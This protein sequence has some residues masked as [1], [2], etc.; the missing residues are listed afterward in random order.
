MQPLSQAI[1][2]QSSIHGGSPAGENIPAFD[3]IQSRSGAEYTAPDIGVAVCVSVNVTQKI[4][5][6]RG[7]FKAVRQSSFTA[8]DLKICKRLAEIVAAS[9][10]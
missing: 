7:E 3:L 9:I 2:L 1:F 10:L 4:E 5:A 6:R 8:H